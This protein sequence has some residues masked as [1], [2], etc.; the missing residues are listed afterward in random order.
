MKS[1]RLYLVIGILLIAAIGAVL[2]VL[3]GGDEEFGREDK[4]DGRTTDPTREYVLGEDGALDLAQVAV[5]YEQVLDDYKQWAKYPPDSRPLRAGFIDQI[6][7]HWIPLPPQNMPIPDGK[8]GLTEPR[9]ACLLQPQ[10]HTVTEGME[11]V[12]TLRCASAGEG[13]QTVPVDIREIKLIRTLDDKTWQTETPRVEA[14]TPANKHEYRLLYRPRQDDWGDMSLQVN[15]AIPGEPGGFVHTLKTHF[16]SSPTAPA[17][18]NG[19]VAERIEDGSLLVSAELNVRFPGRYTIEANLFNANGPVAYARKD[20]R[21]GG[22]T[23]RVDLEFFGKIFH[24]QNAEAPYIVRGL[25]GIQD[26]DPLDPADLS[27]PVEEVQKM[28]A[29]LKTTQPHKRVIPNF[30]KDY[31][32]QE[33]RLAEF[34]NR[35]WDSPIKRE[36]MAELGQLAGQ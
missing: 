15:F 5:T 13:G 28:L 21:L 2:F 35:E 6:E 22:G 31:T 7:F 11:M 9:H 33:Y 1:K 10:T 34:S 16:F 12:V 14:G 30:E 25:R 18:F 3:F 20:A 36:R 26:T 23:Q 32:T 17:R 29:T 27:K 19:I 8:G 24:D 4:I